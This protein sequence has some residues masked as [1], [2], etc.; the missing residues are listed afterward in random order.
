[1]PVLHR[2]GTLLAHRPRP[3]LAAG[4][5]LT[6]VLAV[7]GAG[8][9][10]AMILNRWEAPGTE[11]VRAQELLQREFHTGN[12][13]FI[14]LVTAVAGGVDDATV[15]DAGREL[16]AELR[17]DPAVADAWSYWSEEGDP[18]MRSADGRQAVVLAHVAGDA[19]TAR[20]EIVDRL[21]PAYTRA[22]DVVRVQVA[23]A[24][25]ASGQISA[26][27]AQDFLR[28]E[29][30]ILPVM[31]LLLLLM[32]RR[33]RL[34][35]CTLG[36][37]VFSV[38][39]TLA[40]LRGV[41]ARTDVSTFAA[42]ITLVMGI[43]L[44]VDYSLFVITRFREELGRGATVSDAVITSVRTAGRTVLFSGATVAAALAVLLVFP[45]SFL[46]SFAYAG[47][48]VVLMACLGA[49]VLLPAALA[50]I[51]H[52]ALPRRP[53]ASAETERGFWYR[54]GDAVMRYP[55]R[56]SIAGLLLI[57]VLAAPALGMR[58]GLPDDRVLPPSAS[59]RQAY[60]ELRAA[61]A[62]EAN[63]AIHFVAPDGRRVGADRIARYA[64]ELS[65]IDGV[66]Q[67]NSAAGVFVDGREVRAVPH[68]E[69]FV[70]DTAA[71]LEAVPLREV[72]A[73]T[74]VP[75]FVAQLRA[76]PAPFDTV[77]VGG[78][79]AELTDFRATLTD[80]IPLVAVL[81]AVVTFVLVFLMSGSLLIP[82]KA[83]V[84]NLLSLSVMFGALVFIFQNGA[85]ATLLGF[86]PIGTLDPAFPILLFCVA[87]GLSMDYEVFLLSRIAER[88]RATGDNRRAVL[89][90]LQRAAPLITAAAVILAVSFS[91]YA[92]GRVM[93]L[94]MLGIGTA[95]AIIVD[96]TL[97]RAVLVPAF[98]RLAGRANWW[99]PAPLRKLAA[100]F[101]SHA[102]D[103]PA[104][105][106]RAEVQPSM[107]VG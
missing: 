99:A 10:G 51:G 12:A 65:R 9:M 8:A 86:T 52:R 81:I 75:G 89:E 95:V 68:P 30:I 63:D 34:A 26:Q 11:S 100:R 91:L 53:R 7:I 73:G 90:G 23:G 38:V 94:Q 32:F 55:V 15:A 67:V 56:F 3:V 80:R 79:P 27:A 78:Y 43:G 21:L 2:L 62:V 77:L 88:Y 60:D 41:A 103:A 64:V 87:Y 28:A 25:A 24:E 33:T 82:L 40:A 20:A 96:A 107:P 76:V 58:I 42:N 66:A 50:V 18:T 19:T 14:L 5:L 49:L 72:L 6:I 29:M 16:T 74:D 45:Y 92:T 31:L 37:G 85:L 22:D 97:I 48:L 57:A 84:L 59:T 36:V 17:T 70:G 13:N 83:I 98:M 39:A 102:G 61:F 54:F 105:P 69:R 71:R 46:R 4:L 47:V 1:M 35:L 101:D 44:G 104:M 93:Y 106:A